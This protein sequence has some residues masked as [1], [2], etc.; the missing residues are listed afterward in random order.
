[1]GPMLRLVVL[2]GMLAALTVATV[3][4][5]GLPL[6][7]AYADSGLCALAGVDGPAPA[8]GGIVNTYYPGAVSVAAGATQIQLGA[9]DPAG[10]ASP[11]VVGDLLLIIQ[12][13]GATVYDASDA[14]YG[15]NDGS[16]S[17]ATAITAGGYEYA[18]A[19][20]TLTTAGGTLTIRG[21]SGGGLQQAYTIA[22]TVWSG[23]QGQQRFQ[24]IR[25]PQ[26]SSATLDAATPL[27]A[28]PWNGATGGVVALDVAG[29]LAMNGG[30]IDVSARG[31]RG[32]G[33]RQLLG[34]IAGT[35]I[36]YR[37]P[38]ARPNNA[39]KGEGIAGTPRFVYDQAA[40]ALIDTA[41]PGGEGYPL[42][43]SA[44]GAPG[45]AGG[46]GTDGRPSASSLV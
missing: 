37:T 41:P 21:M 11:I 38:A 28:P 12:M 24:V 29:R 30:T 14:T 7:L 19:G 33:G 6:P 25:V 46:G 32:G 40:S 10:A 36:D 9:A 31:F 34:A 27:T 4:P 13:Q 18:V 3:A 42:G 5:A 16:G 35:N 45:N 44:R 43:S 1:M 17:G 20:G 26:Y 15:A 8:L 2:I 22:N 39:A 23:S